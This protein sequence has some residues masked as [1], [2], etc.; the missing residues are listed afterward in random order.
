MSAK[1]YKQQRQLAQTRS[2]DVIVLPAAG[3]AAAE[4]EEV[5]SQGDEEN[6]TEVW[7]DMKFSLVEPRV[8]GGAIMAR[9]SS[10]SRSSSRIGCN[11]PTTAA[12][13]GEGSNA[14]SDSHATCTVDVWSL[15]AAIRPRKPAWHFSA[16][17]RTSCGFGS[18]GSSSAGSGNL[19]LLE[20]EPNDAAVHPRQGL[21]VLCFE[22]FGPRQLSGSSSSSSNGRAGL[23]ELLLAARDGSRARCESC[24]DVLFAFF[25]LHITWF[26]SCQSSACRKN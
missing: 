23:R 19:Q 22:K 24:V 7:L 11:S 16:A 5:H 10:N 4:G 21:G 12:A 14:S 18:S 3:S 1:L 9:S 25:G 8:K 20:L 15:D 2:T 6:H 17:A 13:A 26:R